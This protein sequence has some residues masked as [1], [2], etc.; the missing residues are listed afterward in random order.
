MTTALVT[1]ASSGI[2]AELARLVAADGHDVVLVARRASELGALAAELSGARVIVAD[3]ADPASPAKLVAEVPDVDL[4]VNN[5]GVGDFGPFA[6]A[7]L[8]KTTAMIQLNVTSLT[9]LTRWYLPGMLDRG[10][11]QVLNVASTAAFQPGPLMAVYYAT[12]A[13]V[14]S[15]SE[16]IA[17]ELRGSGVTVTALCPGPTASGFQT[18]AAMEGS[19][20]VKDRRLP[21]AATVARAG[22]RA[23]RRGDVVAVV[24]ARNKFLAASVRFTP[25]PVIR[26]LVGRMQRSD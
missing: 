21:S 7:D 13:Y 24:G 20:L 4:L 18:G 3:L 19:R 1:G 9:E 25:R 26:R 2:G 11:G 5:A 23:L 12:K 14:L 6:D 17:E 16:A 22:H 15:F 10:H 8:A